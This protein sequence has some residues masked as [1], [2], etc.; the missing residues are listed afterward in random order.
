MGVPRFRTAV[1]LVV[2]GYLI[3]LAVAGGSVALL[4]GLDSG[5]VGVVAGGMAMTLGLAVAVGVLL[6]TTGLVVA[7]RGAQA[8]DGGHR[9]R[10]LALATLPGFCAAAALLWNALR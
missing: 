4:T 9:T 8:G 3:P 10:R 2:A 1:A 7:A 6:L 5:A